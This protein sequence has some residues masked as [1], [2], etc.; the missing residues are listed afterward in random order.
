MAAVGLAVVIAGFISLTSSELMAFVNPNEPSMNP[1]AIL[2]SLVWVLPLMTTKDLLVASLVA[3]DRQH[4][5]AWSLTAALAVSI[6]LH[7]LL[8]FPEGASG[9][10]AVFFI[11]EALIISLC[12]VQLLRATRSTDP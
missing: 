12:A 8:T 4:F 11:V 10:I 2:A 6:G 9:L 3:S 7:L 1:A 5:L